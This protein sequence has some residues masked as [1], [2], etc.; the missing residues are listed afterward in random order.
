MIDV[1]TSKIIDLS[2]KIKLQVRRLNEIS[3]ELYLWAKSDQNLDSD[4]AEL[5][6]QQS[7]EIERA[8]KALKKISLSMEKKAFLCETTSHKALEI[9]AGIESVFVTDKS[10]KVKL[11]DFTEISRLLSD[12]KFDV[13]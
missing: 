4:I 2:E 3:S 13:G 11:N 1:S 10:E 8:T 5:I 9:M 6:K 12:Y 7:L